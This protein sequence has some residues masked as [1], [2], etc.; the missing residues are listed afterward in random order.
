MVKLIFERLEYLFK[1]ALMTHGHSLSFLMP[2]TTCQCLGYDNL[3]LFAI[4]KA[5][6][7]VLTF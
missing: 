1:E 3:L 6:L 5:W 4:S 7:C 2:L